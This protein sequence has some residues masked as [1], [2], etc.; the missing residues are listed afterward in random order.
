MMKVLYLSP[1][2]Y[3]GGAERF[4]LE[5]NVA[6]KNNPQ[7]KSEILFLSH[8]AAV[9]KAREYEL[10]HYVYDQSFRFR[11]PLSILKLVFSIRKLIIQ[12]KYEIVHATM[13]Y[14]H[15]LLSLAC[16]GLKVKKVW[17]Q[18]GPVGGKW[19]FFANFFHADQIYFNTNYLE[20]EHFKM[21]GPFHGSIENHVVHY[22]INSDKADDNEV[23]QIKKRFDNKRII[24]S[25]GRICPWKAIEQSI[26]AFK[27]IIHNNPAHK[28]GFHLVIVGDVGRSEDLPYKEMLIELAHGYEDCITFVGQT[29][30]PQNY[31][32]ASSVF[33]HTSNIPEPFGLVVGEAMIQ[34]TLVIG[35][36][37]G[38]TTEMLKDGVTGYSYNTTSD[39]AVSLLEQKL[40]FFMN[41]PD[42]YFM[43]IKEAGKKYIENNFNREQLERKLSKLYLLLK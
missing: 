26:N 17:F 40:L 19:D 16:R 2:G 21:P 34:G 43:K 7:I 24:L 18:H 10:A 20:N 25:L 1:N 13:P 38:G 22:S 28:D 5:A 14:A 23:E 32:K 39:E 35:S 30:N 6:H 8:G 11:N 15:I 9:D 31:M 36:N 42:K 37:Q 4:V 33:L 41:N 27:N 3:L 29:N 12:E